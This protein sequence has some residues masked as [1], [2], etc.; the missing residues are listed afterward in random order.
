MTKNDENFMMVR[1]HLS[2]LRVYD[3][4]KSIIF[5]LQLINELNNQI[6]NIVLFRR[7]DKE[8]TK[9]NVDDLEVSR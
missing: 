4:D 9:N 5:R 1:K 7:K 2:R 6:H 3:D 8:K